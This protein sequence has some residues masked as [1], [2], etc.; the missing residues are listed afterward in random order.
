MNKKRFLYTSSKSKTMFMLLATTFYV[1]PPVWAAVP[2]TTHQLPKGG[3]VVA[4]KASI[5]QHAATMDVT[6]TTHRSVIN[7]ETFDIGSQARVNFKQPT[8]NSVALNRVIQSNN[9]SQIFGRLTANGQLF[10]TNA[11]GVYFAPGASVNVGGLVAT[12]HNISTEEFMDGRYHFTRDGATGAVV[13]EASLVAGL[14]KYIALL[15][16]EVRNNGVVIAERGTVVLAAGEAYTL[17]FSNQGGLADITV[18]KST[19]DAL[20]ENRQ[21]IQAPGGLVVLSA[22]AANTLQGGVVKQSGTI[23]AAGLV[24][25]GGIVRLVASDQIE[26]AGHITADAASGSQGKGG[27]VVAIADLDTPDSKMEFSGVISARGGT[28]GGNG[29]FVETSGNFVTVEGSAMVDTLATQGKTGKWLI[30]PYD[31]TINAAAATAIEN[32]LTLSNVEVT[33]SADV[34]GYG[35]NGNGASTGNIVVSSDIDSASANELTLT[36]ANTINVGAEISVGSL[37]LNGPGGITLSDDLTTQT[38][39]TLNGNVTLGADVVLTTGTSNTYA[40]YTTYTVPAGVTSIT[41]TLAGG[42]GGEG[43]DD[44]GNQG[45]TSGSVGSVTASFAVTPGQSI[46]IAPGAAGS[47]GANS[48]SNAAGGAGGTNQFNIGNGGAGGTAGPVGSSGGGGGGGAATVLSFTNTPTTASNLLI[49]GGGGGGGGS[50]NNAACPSLCG[51]Q[52]GANYRNDGIFT[53]ETGYNAGNG[54]VPIND[55]GASGGGGGGL[56]GGVSNETVFFSN[57]WTGRGGNAG[58][59]GVANSFATTSISTS[60]TNIGNN[61]AGSATLSYGGG[62]I[63]INGTINGGQALTISAPGSAIDVSGAI[64][65]STA[66]SSLSMSGSQG[67]G[68]S[69]G[70]VTTS[71]TQS[72]TGP[73]TLNAANNNFT[74]TNSA[75]TFGGAVSKGTGVSSNITTSTGSGVVSFNG[76]V[77]TSGTPVGTVN[78]TTTGATNIAGALYATSLTKSGTGSTKISGGQVQT[79]GGQSYAGILDLGG[80][81]A[82]SSTGSG[83]FTFSQAISND[84]QSNLTINA[85][86]GDVTFVGNMSVGTNPIP[87]PIGDVAITASGTVTFGSGGTPVSIDARSLSVTADTA[88]VYAATSNFT[89]GTGAT[90][91]GVCLTS[92]ASVDVASASTF[93]GPLSG[94]TTLTKAGAGSLT[95]TGTNTY[96]GNTTV[97]AGKLEIGG[98]GQLGGGNY[99]GNIAVTGQV[100]FNTSSNN[101]LTGV[102]SGSGFINT[103]G[104]GVTDIVTESNRDYYNLINAYVVPTSSGA[105]GTSVYGDPISFSHELATTA[106][107][108][109]AIVDASPSGTAVLTGAP[110]STS[111][112]GNY[113][114]S[115]NNGLTLGNERYILTAGNNLAWVIAPRPL[116]VTVSKAYDGSAAF[117]SGLALSGTVNGDATPALM[118]SASVASANAGSYNSFASSTLTQNDANYTLTGGTVD[119]T[120]STVPLSIRATKIYDGTTT[121]N[122]GFEVSGMVNGDAAPAI[123]GTANIAGSGVGHYSEFTSSNL[124]LDNSNYTF[125]NDGVFAIVTPRPLAVTVSK[126][127]DGT[128]VF[129]SGFALTGVASG[130]YTPTITGSA[131]V[132]SSNAGSYYSF[133]NTN[134]TLSL[135]NSNY[136]LV[137][138][139][140]SAT[141]TPLPLT[142]TASKIYDGTTLFDDNFSVS[143]VL[144]GELAP[145][146]TGNAHTSSSEAGT[147]TSF[148]ST[149]LIVNDSNYT[150]TGGSVSATISP[151]PES[152]VE[153]DTDTS[154]ALP[155]LDPEATVLVVF[156]E[157]EIPTTDNRYRPPSTSDA[158]LLPVAASDEAGIVVSLVKEPS[159]YEQGVMSVV[160]P[161]NTMTKGESFTFALPEQVATHQG[162]QPAVLTVSLSD[163]RPLPAWITFNPNNKT[164]V[165]SNVPSGGLPLYVVV[166]TEEMTTTIVISEND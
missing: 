20:V 149:S 65:A 117:S 71:G 128:G 68:L 92:S 132:N 125:N 94:T 158:I 19:I 52:V 134:N 4:G 72:Y 135:D 103:V 97:S 164:F 30:D 147:Y 78:V 46:Y 133:S 104:A 83:N 75:V 14:D 146:V 29:G 136:T 53:G 140:I 57:E 126:P 58:Q 35:S 16:P 113:T 24:E 105:G 122:S 112:A 62:T 79:S 41:A 82:L 25:D 40:V 55:G 118:G 45:G 110:S 108:G 89:C 139:S 37:V 165:A 130:D 56:L 60:T 124:S 11:A 131:S 36:A 90:A 66:L 99:G 61:Q 51:A 150:L 138:S 155:K 12:T 69:G 129:N 163:G 116:T 33:T 34:A 5:H 85:A 148:A 17:K 6:Q 18:S 27:T 166:S 98:S 143:G 142:I 3:T 162:D 119:A 15:A 86:N 87:T 76:A 70:A 73:L 153:T 114:V 107:G 22:Q 159:V 121:F 23:A 10:L 47:T 64:G 50:G 1:A 32:A 88:T 96:S 115:Y 44:G 144:S 9:P 120:I 111:P 48:Q 26:L 81:T 74:S 2:P 101:T 127:Y 95:L 13:N 152:K 123:T 145:S 100:R 28:Q 141:I 38:G 43:G 154:V 102:M 157:D 67:I 63:D 137:G 31:Y 91:K 21:A 160:V 161:Q 80:N 106:G 54:G 59:S 7:W 8:A 109:T 84:T 39:M 151:A 77:G 93:S 49:A 42:A 156:N